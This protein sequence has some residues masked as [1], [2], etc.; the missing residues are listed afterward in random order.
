MLFRS[1][2]QSRYHPLGYSVG[3]RGK[4]AINTNAQETYVVNIDWISEETA[5]WLSYELYNSIEIYT[6]DS[7]GVIVTTDPLK[8]KFYDEIN[9]HHSDNDEDEDDWGVGDVPLTINTQGWKQR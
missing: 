1:V 5:R 7:D 3:D 4:T 6:L 8:K 9:M 2:S